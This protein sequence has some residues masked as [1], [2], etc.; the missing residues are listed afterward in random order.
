MKNAKTVYTISSQ[1]LFGILFSLTSFGQLRELEA[2]KTNWTTVGELKWLANTKASL[3]YFVS[4]TDTTYRLSLQDEQKLK[5][6]TGRT[7]TNYFSIHFSGRDNTLGSLYTLLTSFFT[8][9]NRNNKQLEKIVKLGSEMVHVQHYRS[10]TGHT[11]MFST[12]ENHILL[13]ERELNKLFNR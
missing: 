3:T 2:T 8:E 13:T 1:V 5:S 6:S 4:Q 11:I 12:K 9:E 7:V 10:L